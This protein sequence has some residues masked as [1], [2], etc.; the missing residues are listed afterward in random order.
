MSF[1]SGLFGSNVNLG[2]LLVAPWKSPGKTIARNNQ[3][4]PFKS[5][6]KS[7]FILEL[8]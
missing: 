1:G 3:M 6:C 2:V 4:N 8:T 5:R 7:I